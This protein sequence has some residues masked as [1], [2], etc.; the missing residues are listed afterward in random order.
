MV[1]VRS[2]SADSNCLERG[3]LPASIVALGVTQMAMVTDSHFTPGTQLGDPDETVGPLSSFT[4]QTP[5]DRPAFRL[6]F[7]GAVVAASRLGNSI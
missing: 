6:L 2:S 3:S 5:A 1:E 4:G 7:F